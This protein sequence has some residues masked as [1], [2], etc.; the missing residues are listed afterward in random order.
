M[1]A[2]VCNHYGSTQFT[3]ASIVLQIIQIC[4]SSKHPT[5]HKASKHNPINRSRWHNN[6]QLPYWAFTCWVKLKIDGIS[7]QQ[8]SHDTL[9]IPHAL[10]PHRSRCNSLRQKYPNITQQTQVTVPSLCFQEGEVVQKIPYQKLQSQGPVSNESNYLFNNAIPIIP[11]TSH[12]TWTTLNQI[13]C[14]TK[15]SIAMNN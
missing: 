7:N 11:P 4:L 1:K 6:Y 3:L 8:L 2:V 14:V 15:L 12:P 13:T 10:Q 5:K 9:H